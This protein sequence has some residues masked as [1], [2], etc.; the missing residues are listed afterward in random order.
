MC[1]P[2]VNST[3]FANI[4]EVFTK[5]FIS[6]SWGKKTPKNPLQM[7]VQT[8]PVLRYTQKDKDDFW[9]LWKWN[10][11]TQKNP[12]C[13]PSC[14]WVLSMKQQIHHPLEESNLNSRKQTAPNHINLEA[15][16]VNYK[17]CWYGVRTFLLTL[18]TVGI[19]VER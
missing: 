11:Q 16:W 6:N 19:A 4:L 7:N 15:P 13:L 2:I 9:M 14:K 5:F 1:L 12:I 8:K 3:K 18:Q 10:T 17:V